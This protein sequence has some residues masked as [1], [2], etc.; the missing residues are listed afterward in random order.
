MGQFVVR[1]VP[2]SVVQ[3][4]WWLDSPG[5][6]P[7]REDGGIAKGPWSAG[8]GLALLVALADVLFLD[9]LPGVSLA[10]F[11]L[12]VGAVVCVQ[13]GRV[14]GMVGPVVLLGLSVLPVVEYVQVLS[15]AFLLGGSVVALCWAVLGR[16]EDLGRAIR[17]FLG[18]FPILGLWQARQMAREARNTLRAGGAGAQVWQSWAFPVGGGLLL[19][20]LLISA[21]PVLSDGL[22]RFF[23]AGIRVERVLF[24]LGAALLIWPILAVAVETGLLAPKAGP[25]RPRRMPGLGINAAS[26]ANALILFN[27]LMAVQT[28]MDAVYLW[29]GAALPDGM[30]YAQYAHR[31]AY[32]LVATAL[33]AGAFALAA[34]PFLHE[35][36][37]LRP[38]VLLWLGQNVALVISSLL[39]LSLYVEAY[40]F[41]YLRVHAGIWMGIV[42]VGLCLTAWQI[43]CERPN[44]WLLLRCAVLG[45]AVLYACCFVNFAALIARE[46]LR[47][48]ERYDAYYVCLLGPMAA[49]ELAAAP[50]MAGCEA[51]P[52]RIGNWRE[53]GFRADRVIRSLAVATEPESPHEDPRRG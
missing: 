27:L 17:R 15:V 41:T 16:C 2:A 21:N 36:R 35:R 46:N 43:L 33:L 34:R 14:R 47:Q 51:Q 23:D 19:G 22:E 4:S 29:G 32:P 49:A 18:L 7:E 3:D 9:Y 39:R 53:W 44:R 6:R 20:G 12:A 50:H 28:A 37:G 1:G 38:L 52:P 25:N 26:V 13:L 8:G 11:A 31:G 42:A 48:T 24:W 10:V 45:V 40:G 5:D 30:S